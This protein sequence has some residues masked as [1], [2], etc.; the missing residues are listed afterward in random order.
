MG[1]PWPCASCPSSGGFLL[2]RAVALLVGDLREAWAV[3]L[4]GET[5]DAD[6]AEDDCEESVEHVDEEEEDEEADV[7]RR[8]YPQKEMNINF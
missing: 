7:V 4:K 6:G 1:R 2:A 5:G 8:P 3:S